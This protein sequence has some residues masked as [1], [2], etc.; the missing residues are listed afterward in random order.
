MKSS[1]KFAGKLIRR[2]GA[3]YVVIPDKALALLGR[4]K[5]FDVSIADGRVRLRPKTL[6]PSVLRQTRVKARK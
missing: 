4:P 2:R 3:Y 6:R 1:A 5:T